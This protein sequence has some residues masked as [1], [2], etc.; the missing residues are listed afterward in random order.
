MRPRIAAAPLALAAVLAAA[1]A[2]AI[3]SRA[4]TSG[5]QFLKIGQGSAR[6]QALGGAYAALA[7]GSDAMTWNPAGLAATQQREFAFS[8]LRSVQGLDCPIYLGY[9]QPMGRTAWGGNFGY[10]SDSLGNGDVR[11]A[12]GVPQQ[13]S[14]VNVRDGYGAVGLA[15]SFWYEKLFLGASVRGV[16]E[17][18]AGSSRG[19]LAM[20]LGAMLK[21]ASALS[22]GFAVQNFGA[23]AGAVARTTR[24]GAA[25]RLSDF[26]TVSGELSEATDSGAQL[27]AGAEF[28]L[29]EEYL[30]IGQLTMRVG[31]RNVDSYGQS[32]DGTLKSLRVDQTS[33][34]SFGFGVYTSQAFGYGLSLDY[35]F[36]PYGA[37]GTMD[38][39]SF[40]LKF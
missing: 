18:I 19:T 4:G 16:S 14:N 40:K 9:A 21:P 28:S 35:A 1:P 27:S 12:S 3:D 10:M 17:N 24:G 7:E 37:L 15:R 30:D 23:S 2:R 39:I 20:D 8:Y 36:V 26:V 22:L 29:P 38:Q 34:I 11:D 33:G 6:A 5:A 32:F 25:L 13:A 31:Y